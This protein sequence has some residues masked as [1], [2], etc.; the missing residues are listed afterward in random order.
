M[1]EKIES[2]KDIRVD[3]IKYDMN[4]FLG[5]IYSLNT[6]QGEIYHKYVLG[7]YKFMDKLL[8]G[9]IV[10]SG[11]YLVRYLLTILTAQMSPHMEHPSSFFVQPLSLYLSAFSLSRQTSYM[12][13]QSNAFL[14]LAI[15]VSAS[16]PFP[17]VM[18]PTCAAILDAMRPSLTSSTSGR[19]RCSAGVR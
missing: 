19:L 7:V 3:Y 18:S 4:R 5:D 17:R 6:R 15:A 14:A 8:S 12:A 1:A 9:L 10:R 11:S 13:S 16:W 2:L